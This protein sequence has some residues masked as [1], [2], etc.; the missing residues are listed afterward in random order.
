MD[1]LLRKSATKMSA[2]SRT[3]PLKIR[4]LHWGVAAIILT[5][6]YVL[7]VGD[8]PHRY[9]GY[10]CVAFVITRLLF[11][12]TKTHHYNPKAILV[13]AVIWACILGLGLTGWMM[14]LDRFWGNSTLENIHANLVNLILVLVV[15]HLLG[16]F[17]DAYRFKRKTWMKMLNGQIDEP[18][19]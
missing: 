4:L 5:N 11:W 17:V 16:I 15:V 2:G 7:E 14:G 6:A 13:Y 8:A 1:Q 9:L 10:L 3:L 19:A 12:K 18:K